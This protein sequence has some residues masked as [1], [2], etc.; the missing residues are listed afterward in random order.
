[1]AGLEAEKEHAM[2][3]DLA[4][5]IGSIGVALLLGAFFL[6]LIGVL[7]RETKMYLALNLIGAGLASFASLLI[8]FVPFLVLEGVWTLVSGVGLLRFS[9]TGAL[10]GDRR[11][12]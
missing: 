2:E 10:P 6:N 8:G 12:K 3:F 11:C 4:E 7:T 1:M 5:L 9:T